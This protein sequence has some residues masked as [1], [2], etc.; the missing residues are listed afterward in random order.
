MVFDT[1][2]CVTKASYIC[3]MPCKIS[4]VYLLCYLSVVKISHS[5]HYDSQHL[6]NSDF[7]P[8]VTCFNTHAENLKP[9]YKDF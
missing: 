5:V 3:V 7:W 6:H 8:C 1:V 4:V 2:V 9:K